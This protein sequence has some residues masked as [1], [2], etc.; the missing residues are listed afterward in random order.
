MTTMCRR[1]FAVQYKV[2]A[3]A[4]C[5]SEGHSCTPVAHRQGLLN[6]RLAKLFCQACLDR[7][8]FASSEEGQL[9]SDERAELAQIL[10][11]NQGT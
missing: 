4:L 6:S 10:R 7:G 2:E 9:S 8:D 1:Q 3:V 5:F 11:V